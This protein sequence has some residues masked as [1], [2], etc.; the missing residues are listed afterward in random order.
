MLSLFSGFD[1]LR[2]LVSSVREA[3]KINNVFVKKGYPP[4]V[5]FHNFVRES[6]TLN[7]NYRIDLSAPP[8]IVWFKLAEVYV[9]YLPTMAELTYDVQKKEITRIRNLDQS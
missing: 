7:T 5:E 1:R 8:R 9:Q 4:V 6:P 2:G 3:D